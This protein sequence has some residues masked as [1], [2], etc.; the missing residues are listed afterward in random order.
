MTI[1]FEKT[2]PRTLT[3]LLQRYASSPERGTTLE[4]WMFDDAAGRRKTEAE[5]AARGIKARLRSAYKPLLHFFLED[6]DL[7][8]TGIS[9]V[10]VLYPVSSNAP[11][12]RFLLET[13]PLA[14]L[15]ADIRFTFAAGRHNECVYDLILGNARGE[16]S[17]H[18]VFAPNRV[19]L[20][21]IGESHLSP[22]GWL[23]VGD[24]SGTILHDDRLETDFETL[25]T[26][27][28]QTLADHP[29]GHKEPYFEELNIAV[30]L[31]G[32]DTALG[33]GQE[34]LSLH[35]A[36]HEDLY[37]SLLEIFQRRSG[38]PLGDRGLQPGQI[39]PEIRHGDGPARVMVEILPLTL[40]EVP[41]KDQELVNATSPLTSVQIHSELGKIDGEPFTATSRAGRIVAARYHPG[42]DF[43]VM[44][45]GGQHAN[46]TSGVV[47]A[48][49]AAGILSKR[50][51]SHFTVA[52]L[53]NPDGY[54]LHQR[55][56]QDNPTH[57]HHAARYTAL[58]DDLGHRRNNLYE[59]AI[60]CRALQLSRAHLHIN[61]HGYPS[62]EWTRPLSGYVPRG[63]A[64]WTLPKG[65]FL[66][67]NYHHSWTERAEAFLTEL[68]EKLA[69]VPGLLAFNR[70]QINLYK[71]HSGSSG[72]HIIG[73]FPCML[74]ADDEQDVP[75]ALTTEYPDETCHGTPFIAGH[76][77]QTATALA[78]YAAYQ[79][80][81]RRMFTGEGADPCPLTP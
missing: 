64:L 10:K 18:Q 38:R 13:Y 47:G 7:A 28:L 1:L 79:N 29:W 66:I 32:V 26:D 46:E 78:A 68:T 22:T 53:E 67:M 14:A 60:R 73:G 31:P 49:R 17:T 4:A 6:L 61:L 76:D 72:F 55:L 48:L 50:A 39:V 74:T 44:I 36:L 56:I 2:Y 25:F 52:P 16:E 65:F 19:H 9:E 33:Y 21:T 11:E 63:F 5:F 57:M 30:N 37:F 70:Q 69:E 75:L 58:G 41:G 45:S 35:E 51:G 15:F 20:D 80:L 27:T 43:P 3:T 34:V 59:R 12:N 54:A 23:R 71:L 24:S 42:S 8:T 62:H 77:V 40:G 81:M